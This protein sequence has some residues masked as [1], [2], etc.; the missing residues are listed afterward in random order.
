M[1]CKP[2]CGERSKETS[3]LL[4]VK[5][6]KR[7]NPKPGQEEE[8]K[9]DTEILGVVDSTYKF[10]NLCDFQYLPALR[11]RENEREGEPKYDPIYE[12]VNE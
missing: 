5:R 12:Q 4:K 7:K 2:T 6:K 8:R 11:D 9:L 1:F 3:F 10:G